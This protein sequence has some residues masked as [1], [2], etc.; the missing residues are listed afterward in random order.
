[1][2]SNFLTEDLFKKGLA[3]RI[4]SQSRGG[5]VSSEPW[6]HRSCGRAWGHNST[7]T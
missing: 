7:L 5:G 1:M 4:L 6:P 3:V 2:L